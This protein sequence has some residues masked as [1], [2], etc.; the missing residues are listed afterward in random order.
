MKRHSVRGI[1]ET[2]WR[3]VRAL[4]APAALETVSSLPEGATVPESQPH[5]GNGE[6]QETVNIAKGH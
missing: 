3:S 4:Q 5:P 6:M 2:L 1:Q